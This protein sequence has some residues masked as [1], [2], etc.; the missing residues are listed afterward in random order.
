MPDAPTNRF[1]PTTN[2]GMTVTIE[3]KI[4]YYNA[5]A[6]KDLQE[7]GIPENLEEAVEYIIQATPDEV[8][9]E[10]KSGDTDPTLAHFGLGRW[11]RNNWGLW[12]GSTLQEWFHQKGIRHADDMSGIILETVS[13]EIRDKPWNLDEQVAHYRQYWK[14]KGVNPDEIGRGGDEQE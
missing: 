13:R 1:K 2:Y 10:V 9:E 8:I 11:I 12:S 14:D 7:K 4:N 5:M 6:I 3:D